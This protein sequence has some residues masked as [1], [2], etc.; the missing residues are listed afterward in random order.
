MTPTQLKAMADSTVVFKPSV[1]FGEFVEATVVR[2]NGHAGTV[3]FVRQG[4]EWR[5]S[6]L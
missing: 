5:I 4:K 3:T 1:E 2:T 6:E